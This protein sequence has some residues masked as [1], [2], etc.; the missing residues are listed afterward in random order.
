MADLALEPPASGVEFRVPHSFFFSHEREW[1]RRGALDD[2][3]READ[4]L[5]AVEPGPASTHTQRGIFILL[6]F[7]LSARLFRF[8]RAASRQPARDCGERGGGDV[9]RGC[10]LRFYYLLRT[11]LSILSE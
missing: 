2:A 9:E 8:M 4:A 7:L 11:P 5:Q 10:G 6:T 1:G 3:R